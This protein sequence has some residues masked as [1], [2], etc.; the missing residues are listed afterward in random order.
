MVMSM[1]QPQP[2]IM[3]PVIMVM[4]FVA[5]AV[6][7]RTAVGLIRRMALRHTRHS[8]LGPT[9]RAVMGEAGRK[10]KTG[11]CSAGIL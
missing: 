2:V 5:P 10:S 1:E 3:V 8:W 9:P 7:I 11:A 4:V 6:I